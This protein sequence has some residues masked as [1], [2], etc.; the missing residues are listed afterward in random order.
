MNEFEKKGFSI[1]KIKKEKKL[2]SLRNKFISIFSKISELNNCG[3]VKNDK[4]ILQLYKKKKK[5]WVGAYDQIRLLPELHSLIDEDFLDK[6]K[7][8]SGIKIPAFTSKPIVRVYMPKNIGTTKTVPHIDYPSHRGSKNAVTVWFPLQSLNPKSGTLMVL[9]GSHKFKTIS[10]SIERGTVKRLD[11]S[12]RDYDNQM[13]HLIIKSGEAIVMS[14]F[15]VHSSGNNSS[16]MIRFSID[17]RL[18]DLSEKSY[19][20]RKYYVNQ[21]SYYRK[22]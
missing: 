15:L 1:I 14:Q 12:N 18:N 20:L 16:N 3:K 11:I 2:M 8:V 6:I 13:E 4:M 7:K 19:A 10:G 9:P 21:I 22:R 17:F 5:L